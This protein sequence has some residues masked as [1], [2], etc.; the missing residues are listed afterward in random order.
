MRAIDQ[1]ANAT[2]AGLIIN[3]TC[4]Y[5]SVG[6]FSGWGN[7]WGTVQMRYN[8]VARCEAA[9]S[10]GDSAGVENGSTPVRLS[11]G[12]CSRVWQIMTSN[13]AGSMG[14]GRAYARVN[15]DMG[16]R[17]NPHE[18]DKVLLT[19]QDETAPA[20]PAGDEYP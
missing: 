16:W 14:Q 15:A 1:R 18:G 5:G 13:A 17:L 7:A 9:R 19:A 20:G 6:R 4:R 2:T 10:C 12:N 8:P 3:L 11:V